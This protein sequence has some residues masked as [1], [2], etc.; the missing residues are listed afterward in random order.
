MISQLEENPEELLQATGG[1]QNDVLRQ[2]RIM[3]DLIMREAAESSGEG[4]GGAGGRLGGLV[5]AMNGR[6]GRDS[7]SGGSF[8]AVGP[9]LV[10]PQEVQ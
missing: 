3:R 8:G 6:V 7:A 1:M 2:M 9:V 5:T 10:D 4:R